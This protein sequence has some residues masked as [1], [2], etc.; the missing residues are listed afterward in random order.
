MIPGEVITKSGEIEL[1]Q[2]ADTVTLTVAN[3][4]DRP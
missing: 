1:N 2:G 3:S 4:G